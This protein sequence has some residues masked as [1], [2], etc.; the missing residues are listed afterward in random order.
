M[1]IGFLGKGGSGKSTLSSLV[2]KLLVLDDKHVLAIDADHN[3]DMRFNLGVTHHD[4]YIGK[5]LTDLLEYV[6][7][8]SQKDKYYDAFELDK[9]PIFSLQNLDSYTKKYTSRHN[10]NFL[11]MVAG[12]HNDKIMYGE[13]CSHS[14][15]TPLK[16]YLPFL[17][18]QEN[19]FV[20]VD[21]KAGSD[22]AG[23]GISSGFD[24]GCIVVEPTEYGVKAAH[25]IA[26][27][28]DFF[29]TPY[30]FIGNKLFDEE[31]KVFLKDNLRKEPALFLDVNKDLRSISKIESV[32]NYKSLLQFIYSLEPSNRKERSKQKFQNNKEFRKKNSPTSK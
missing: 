10:D 27:L 1:I 13:Y 28:L 12:P 18:L 2:T 9:E 26:D 31:D 16:V 5:S 30:S 24:H 7:L 25:Q 6:G 17:E 4:H 22:G 20:I 29:G 14:L 8:D 23:T 3:M 19:E 15:C 21:E 32:E 11:M